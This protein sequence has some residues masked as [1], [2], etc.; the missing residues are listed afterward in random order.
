MAIQTQVFTFQ[1]ENNNGFQITTKLNDDETIVIV[2]VEENGDLGLL[3]PH[4]QSICE[5][6]ICSRLTAIGNEMVS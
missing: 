3:W 2:K 5:A 4:I 1:W 6:Y